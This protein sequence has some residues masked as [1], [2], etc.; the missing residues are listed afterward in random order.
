M[1]AAILVRCRTALRGPRRRPSPRGHPASL[2]GGERFLAACKCVSGATGARLGAVSI[3]SNRALVRRTNCLSYW[4]ARRGRG[5]SWWAGRSGRGGARRSSRCQGSTPVAHGCCVASPRGH[6][7]GRTPR[8]RGDGRPC[9]ATGVPGSGDGE[10]RG[11]GPARHRGSGNRRGEREARG[12]NRLLKRQSHDVRRCVATCSS[13][14]CPAAAKCASRVSAAVTTMP[15]A[16]PAA[17]PP[18][19]ACPCPRHLP[20]T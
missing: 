7:S 5:C 14:V 10:G 20:N 2:A 6:V 4:L 18:A 16:R 12:L 1:A 15:G 3:V 11:T 17:P 8:G 19:D 13:R 9:R